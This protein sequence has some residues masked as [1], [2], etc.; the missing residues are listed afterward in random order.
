MTPATIDLA[1]SGALLLREQTRHEIRS[2]LARGTLVR[3]NSNWQMS[4]TEYESLYAEERHLLAV[5]ATARA[6]TSESGVFSYGSAVAIHELPLWRTALRS[7]HMTMRADAATRSSAGVFR[8]RDALPEEDI[9][10]KDGLRVTVLERTVV[11]AIRALPMEAAL[12]LADAAMRRVAWDA[13]TQSYD[14]PA[15][16]AFRGR[17]WEHLHRTGRR[18]GTKQ[19]RVVLE[20]ADGRAESPGESVARLYLLLLGFAPSRLQVT[21]AGPADTVFR[22]DGELPD[23]GYFW[24]FDGAGKYVDPDMTSGRTVEE[25][26]ARQERRD[27]WIV[28]ETGQGIAR[29]GSEHLDTLEIFAGKLRDDGVP[30]PY[31]HVLPF[32]Y[33][34][35]LR[36]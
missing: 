20:L 17:L 15:A 14:T 3:L 10:V 27:R 19:A 30:I 34:V 35:R 6:M 9:E 4:A 33:M 21:V 23:A 18:R 24:E 28:E 11:D 36:G 2:R 26:L 13:A 31:T 8:H 32:A 12:A 22:V 16:E 1:P 5:T 7:V 29:F 25:I